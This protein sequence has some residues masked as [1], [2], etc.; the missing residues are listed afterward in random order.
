MKKLLYLVALLALVGSGFAEPFRVVVYGDSN[1]YGWIPNPN[2]PSTRYSSEQR[3][4]GVLHI[5]GAQ[6]DGSA[7]LQA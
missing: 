1:T 6:L 7:Y 2:P 4:P 5:S 3:W